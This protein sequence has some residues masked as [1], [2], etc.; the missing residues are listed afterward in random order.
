M[1]YLLI[2]LKM[3]SSFLP[4]TFVACPPL[5]FELSSATATNSYK[6]RRKKKKTHTHTHTK[7]FAKEEEAA[8][9]AYNHAIHRKLSIQCT[10]TIYVARYRAHMKPITWL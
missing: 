8:A 4:S 3:V 10:S 1:N 6:L 2:S 5:N 7:L 9:A